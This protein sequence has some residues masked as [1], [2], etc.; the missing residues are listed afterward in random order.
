M[1]VVK[2]LV[3]VT[4]VS[5]VVVELV[6]NELVLVVLV[7]GGGVHGVVMLEHVQ[8]VLSVVVD[9]V[10]GVVPTVVE[11]RVQSGQTGL[12]QEAT[13]KVGSGVRTGHP[14]P[15][16]RQGDSKSQHA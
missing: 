10:T 15:L 12:V 11:L 5:G 8:G 16:L 4:L 9:E 1:L 6:V 3:L 2:E 7:V 14:G 13:V